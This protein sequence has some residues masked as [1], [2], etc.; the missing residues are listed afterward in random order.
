MDLTKLNLSRDLY[1]NVGPFFC[2]S[3]IELL[4]LTL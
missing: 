1:V 3:N 4:R 2:M